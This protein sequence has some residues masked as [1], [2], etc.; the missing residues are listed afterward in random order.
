MNLTTLN[1]QARTTG[2]SRDSQ[3]LRKS[4][5]IPAT[6]YGHGQEALSISVSEADLKVVLAPGKR[7]TLLDLVID[8]KGG[9]PA[10]VHQYQKHAISQKITHVDFLKIDAETPVK[11]RIPVKL[12]G[13]PVGVKNQGGMLSQENRYLKLWAKP[14]DIPASIDLDISDFG[15]GIT[16]YARSLE[17]GAA[18]LA[19]PENLVIFTISKARGKDAEAD[20]AAE[21]PEGEKK[22]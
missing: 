21:A 19:S 7:Y 20:A 22:K 5:S 16:F 13:L 1:A 2:S 9:N 14:A 6:Y 8:G 17:L 4:G 12:S 10:V 11:V 3:R 15:A 18:K